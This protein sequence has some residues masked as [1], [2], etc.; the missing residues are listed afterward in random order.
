M[1]FFNLGN[2]YFPG[3]LGW[4]IYGQNNQSDFART[5]VCLKTVGDCNSSP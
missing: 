3:T 4:L 1:F 5:Q 2:I